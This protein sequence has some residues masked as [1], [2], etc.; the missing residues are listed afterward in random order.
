[1]S[2]THDF[3]ELLEEA[4]RDPVRAARIEAYKAAMNET[5]ALAEL[6]E[7]AG[8]TQQEVAAALGVSQANVSRIEHEENLYLSTLREYVAALGGRLELRAVFP[9]GEITIAPR[10]ARSSR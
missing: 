8:A 9:D 2:H 3:N 6:R 5:I 4:R 10:A 1:M 7:Q